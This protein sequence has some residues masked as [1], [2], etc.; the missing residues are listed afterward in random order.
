LSLIDDRWLLQNVTLISHRFYDMFKRGTDIVWGLVLGAV[1]LILLPFVALAIKLEDGG[2]ILLAQKRIG[3]HAKEV[4]LYKFR[5][6]AHSDN[7]VW[8]IGEHGEHGENHITRV[9]AFL[10]RTHIDEFPQAWNVLKGDI[11]IVGPRPDIK[12][13]F[14]TI[15]ETVPFYK[16]RYSITPGLTGWAQT[17]Q[18]YEQGNLSPQSLDE[19][20]SRL[21]YDLYYLKNRSVLLDLKIIFR[22]FKLLLPTF[23]FKK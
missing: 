1:T 17:T 22:T 18:Q 6:M 16:L 19:T 4:T 15:V 12:G 8:K 10:R 11:S 13:L 9:G 7:G 14:D 20:R 5:S 3:K 21:Q 23:S 2:P